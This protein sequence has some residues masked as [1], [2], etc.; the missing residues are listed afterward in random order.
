MHASARPHTPNEQSTFLRV[1]G[2]GA[3]HRCVV[4]GVLLA[5]VSAAHAADDQ[6]YDS[7]KL[8]FDLFWSN[9]RPTGQFTSA[10]RTGSLDLRRDIG[11]STYST[12]FGK[13]DWKFTHKN[14][15]YFFAT[16]FDQSKTVVLQRNVTFQGQT[17]SAGSTAKGSL[18]STL[19]VPG[20]QYDFIRRKQ[21]SLGVQVQ[22]DIIDLHGSLRATQV[23]N[24]VA[25]TVGVSSAQLRV[26]LPVAG[27]T[28]RLYPI[29]HSGRLFVDANVLVMYFFGYG[30][31]I[32]S[33][34]TLGLTITKNL[35]LRGGYQLGSRT[36]IHTKAK[37]V[38]V[39]LSQQGAVAG[40]EVSF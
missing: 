36:D 14:H 24:G 9:V 2:L 38:G 40:L 18:Q 29:P 16:R 11:F 25:Q 7:Y 1:F 33:I 37:R 17:F 22:L 3:L 15:L 39:S 30:N 28:V 13:V 31:F 35:A 21:G 27:P 8:R 10:G 5:A 19:Y 34:G 26:P 6:E 12:L 4:L 32:S 20:Y 23:N